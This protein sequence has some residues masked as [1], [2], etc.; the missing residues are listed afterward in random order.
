MQQRH[1]A[2]RGINKLLVSAILKF[3]EAISPFMMKK[4]S[5]SSASELLVDNQNTKN[6]LN[7][8]H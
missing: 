6:F 7:T 2:Q 4:I 1:R 3:P 5:I 8:S